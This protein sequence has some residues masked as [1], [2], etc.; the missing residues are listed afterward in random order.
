MKMELTGMSFPMLI[1]NSEGRLFKLMA[2]DNKSVSEDIAYQS[3]TGVYKGTNGA[4][5]EYREIEIEGT[6]NILNFGFTQSDGI[7]LYN[8]SQEKFN[9]DEDADLLA[10]GITQSEISDNKSKRTIQS[11]LNETQ[12]PE[13][14]AKEAEERR[15]AKQAKQSNQENQGQFT[16]ELPESMRLE[17]EARKKAKQQAQQSLSTSGETEDVVTDEMQQIINAAKAKRDAN[18]QEEQTSNGTDALMPNNTSVRSIVY[19]PKGKA[20]QTYTI[21]GTRI[22]NKNGERNG[23]HKQFKQRQISK[24]KCV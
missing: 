8:R 15:R 2:I 17:A 23:R 10:F 19:T 5:A 1:K 16:E 18:K 24:V 12:L 3:I 21:E 14:M 13:K 11:Q 22:L 4:K 20:T 6:N 7:A 9:Q